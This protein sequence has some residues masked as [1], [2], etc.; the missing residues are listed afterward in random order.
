MVMDLGDFEINILE[1]RA[2]G[3]LGSITYL[4]LMHFYVIMPPFSSLTSD[5]GI[6]L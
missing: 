6:M 2:L 5:R 3:S 4:Y 1:Y